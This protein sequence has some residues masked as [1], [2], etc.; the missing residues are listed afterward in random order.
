[1]KNTKLYAYAP[2]K[3]GAHTMRHLRHDVATCPR[4]G[5]KYFHRSL[6]CIVCYVTWCRNRQR[7]KVLEKLQ[8][9][10]NNQEII[11]RSLYIY[12]IHALPYGRRKDEDYRYFGAKSKRRNFASF[13]YFTLQRRRRKDAIL[14]LF[15]ISSFRPEITKRRSLSLYRGEVEK[16]QFCVF[17]SSR[18]FDFTTK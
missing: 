8:H 16:T 7:V 1:M 14:R 12:L 5:G 3:F 2:G 10:I 17:S 18:Y 11:F 4:F 6:R 13:R 15:V 9:F